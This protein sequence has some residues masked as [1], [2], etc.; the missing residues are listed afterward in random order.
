MNINYQL[1]EFIYE[2][3]LNCKDNDEAQ[4]KM[5]DDMCE[6]EDEAQVEVFPC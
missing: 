6:F 2:Q 4:Q 1:T 3:K 5:C